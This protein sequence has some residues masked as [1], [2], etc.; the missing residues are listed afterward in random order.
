MCPVTIGGR[1]STRQKIL[2]VNDAAC[3]T[4][5]YEIG[6]P[7]VYSAVDDG[8]ADVASIPARAKCCCGTYGGCRVVKRSL[9]LAVRADVG[10]IGI[11]R[12]GGEERACYPNLCRA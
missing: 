5:G 12:D 4:G 6:M 2:A 10:N 11:G 8:D 1:G 3:S 7:C 9:K